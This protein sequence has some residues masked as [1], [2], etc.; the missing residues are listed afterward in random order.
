MKQLF[1]VVMIAALLLIGCTKQA[2]QQATPPEQQQQ[3]AATPPAATP[4]A[5]NTPTAN[6]PPTN[7]VEQA[8]TNLQTALNAN[9]PYYCKATVQGGQAEMW[10]KNG[11]VKSDVLVTAN[12]AQIK[13]SSLFVDN[14]VYTW[15]GAK[16]FK[17]DMDEIK[18]LQQQYPSL[19]KNNIPQ[20]K[21]DYA[22]S[23]ADVRC[24]VAVIPDSTF[25]VPSDVTF[26]DLA[27]TLNAAMSQL[28]GLQNLQG[29]LPA[30]S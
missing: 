9:V 23:A 29:K 12:N 28:Q 11:K 22:Q 13:A 16:G 3:P 1:I 27:A 15:Q 7:P 18:K 20:G 17:V 4:P 6:T 10:V 8:V 2:Q 24:T 5:A 19:P 25:A 26:E 14:T 21:T 30:Y